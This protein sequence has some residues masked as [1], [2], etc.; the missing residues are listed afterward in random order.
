[1][2]DIPVACIPSALTAEEAARSQ[3]LRA[4]L[5]TAILRVRDEA[6]GCSFE[7][8]DDPEVFRVAAEWIGL[9]RRCCPCHS[10]FDGQA[11]ISRPRCGSAAL[12][13]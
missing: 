4:R 12:R 10:S 9:E 13:V 7:Y 1:M 2:L 8:P 3:Q 6:D 5:A 11:A